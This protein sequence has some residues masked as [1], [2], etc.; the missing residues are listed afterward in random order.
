MKRVLLPTDFSENS[1][2]AI[3]FAVK[4]FQFE[5]CEFYILNVQKASS[6]VSDDLMTMQPSTTIYNSL[7]NASKTRVEGI[8]SELKL[9]YDN[10]LH[11]Y[12]SCVDYDNFIDA[13]NQMIKTKHIDLIV[14]GTKGKTNAE[15]IIFGSNSVR[16]MQRAN[17][18][19]LV[20][21]E[22]YKFTGIQEVVFISNYLSHYKPDDLGILVEL[23][24]HYNY[25]VKVLH[26][27]EDET[28]TGEQRNNR[29]Y[30]DA[31]F[32]NIEHKFVTLKGDD[33]LNSVLNYCDEFNTDLLCMMSRKHSFLERL[34]NTH[35]VEKFAFN[36]KL[37]M[38]IIPYDG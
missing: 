13:I 20:I 24:E 25:S 32:S 23:C 30:L 12:H 3:H 27:N 28:L 19:V 33:V 26:V 5:E 1:I 10:V 7:I 9:Q 35:N 36:A 2:N 16:V 29:A 34:F 37:P 15:S 18:P 11:G 38:L 31:Y 4:Q 6:F 14:M 22:A 8:V 17:C 21:P